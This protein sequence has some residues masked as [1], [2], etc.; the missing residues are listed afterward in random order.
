L[1][2]AGESARKAQPVLRSIDL[3]SLLWVHVAVLGARIGLTDDAARLLGCSQAW[4]DANHNSPDSTIVR[5]YG[6]VTSELEAALGGAELARLRTLGAAMV[7]DAAR[8]LAQSVV[9][10]AGSH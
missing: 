7:G 4:Y 2:E 8:Q 10:A 6:I 1:R 9:D 5:L 3:E